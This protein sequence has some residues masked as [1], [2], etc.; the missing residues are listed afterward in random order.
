MPDATCPGSHAAFAHAKCKLRIAFAHSCAAVEA[1]ALARIAGDA[2]FVDPHNGGTYSLLDRA[3]D[4]SSTIIHGMRI[5]GSGS[6]THYTDKFTLTLSATSQGC[7]V[8]ACSESQGTSMR[9]SSTNYCNLHVLYCSG[10][11]GCPSIS[12]PGFDYDEEVLD[13]THGGRLEADARKCVPHSAGV[14]LTPRA[15]L[16]RSQPAPPPVWL[17]PL[18]RASPPAHRGGGLQPSTPSWTPTSPAQMSPSTSTAHAAWPPPSPALPR[19]PRSPPPHASTTVPVLI[20]VAGGAATLLPLFAVAV[21]C[22]LR[23]RRF[24]DSDAARGRRV[25]RAPLDRSLCQL[26]STCT[27][28]GGNASELAVVD[29]ALGSMMELN[30]AAKAA[31]AASQGRA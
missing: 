11:Q 14:D 5:T 17:P 24:G 12:E 28:A 8:I 2:G 30:D 31:L 20:Y 19:P 9:D 3:N 29:D 26:G 6:S 7:D 16:Q 4:T 22:A 18:P 21:L 15:P 23:C 13:C 27:A 10:S 1:E 25:N